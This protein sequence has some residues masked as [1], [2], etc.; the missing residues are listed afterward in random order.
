MAN[1]GTAVE[2][3]VAHRTPA[4]A[5]ICTTVSAQMSKRQWDTERHSPINPTLTVKTTPDSGRVDI[6]VYSDVGIAFVASG[7]KE[8]DESFRSS[9]GAT[10]MNRFL[11]S[12]QTKHLSR[13]LTFVTLWSHLPL[14][15]LRIS[16]SRTIVQDPTLLNTMKIVVITTAVAVVA[17]AG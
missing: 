11:V 3:H 10:A 17:A 8:L 2:V 13:V 7:R 15:K 5:P 14:Y 9:C 4:L 1:I 16:H 12:L 6:V